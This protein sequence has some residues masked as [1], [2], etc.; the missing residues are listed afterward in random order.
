MKNIHKFIFIAALIANSTSFAADEPSDKIA[1]GL[2]RDAVV[3]LVGSKPTEETC[4][5]YLGVPSCKLT[6][7]KGSA[8]AG[9][10]TYVVHFVANRV[11]SVKTTKASGVFD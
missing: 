8:I 10:S 3:A 6:F 7:T 1:V 4:T 9:K 5:S 2:T 11:V